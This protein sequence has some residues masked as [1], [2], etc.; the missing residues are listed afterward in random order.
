MPLL[1]A[2]PGTTIVR[3]AIPQDVNQLRTAAATPL[4]KSAGAAQ[5]A[6]SNRGTADSSDG[7]TMVVAANVP[8]ASSSVTAV[9]VPSAASLRRR[10]APSVASPAFSVAT[11]AAP[12]S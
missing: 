4:A 8:S 9:N 1:N 2:A 3:A 5:T 6:S 10:A 7:P 12:P 11:S